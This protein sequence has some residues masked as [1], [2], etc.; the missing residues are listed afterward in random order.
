V[1]AHRVVSAAHPGSIV[2]MHNQIQTAQAL[3]AIISGL[4]RKHLQPVG[5]AQLFQAGGFRS[6]EA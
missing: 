4:R 3:P 6:P 5:L 2:V 1:I